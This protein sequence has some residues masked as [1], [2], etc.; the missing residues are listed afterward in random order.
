MNTFKQII[1]TFAIVQISRKD[2]HRQ[3]IPIGINENMSFPAVNFFP[4]RRT[5]VRRQLPWL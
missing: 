2:T 1:G 4:I 3:D 5:R